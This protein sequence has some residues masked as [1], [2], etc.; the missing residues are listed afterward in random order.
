MLILV[1]SEKGGTGKTTMA[2]N[3]AVMRRR[4]GHEV[5]LVDT[6]VQGSASDWADVRNEQGVDPALPCVKKN[7]RIGLDLVQLKKKFDTVIV[8]AGG[9]DSVE[10]RQAMAV[11]DRMLIPMRPSQFDTW[12]MGKMVQ[13]ITEVEEKIEAKLDVVTVLNMVSANA[14]VKEAQEAIELLREYEDRLVVMPRGVCERV[15]FRRA[16]RG[17]LGVSE[18]T[19]SSWDQKAIQEIQTIYK[20]LFR[21]DPNT[22]A[23]KRKP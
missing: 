20:E 13:L 9:Q 3:L 8:D 21:E 5:L 16:A 17:G 23:E 2:V 12:T 22:V 4:A 18:L 14:Q 6:D 11:C 19:G 7:G 15:S 1:G 10:L